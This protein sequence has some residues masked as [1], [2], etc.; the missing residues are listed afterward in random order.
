MKV[1]VTVSSNSTRMYSSV[2]SIIIHRLNENLSVSVQLHPNVQFLGH[3][4]LN[5]SCSLWLCSSHSYVGSRR[6]FD[7]LQGHIRV[8]P[9]WLRN[10]QENEHKG[11]AFS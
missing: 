2:V 11:F 10:V 8:H 1:M 4:S 7:L 9:D 6:Y 3:N 5:S